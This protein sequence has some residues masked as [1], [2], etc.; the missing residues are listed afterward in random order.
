MSPALRTASP[1][2]RS[3]ADLSRPEKEFTGIG[4]PRVDERLKMF[5]DN[6]S[7]QQL[8]RIYGLAGFQS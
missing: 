4:R 1:A 3:D 6:G 5:H 2:I 7:L 8:R